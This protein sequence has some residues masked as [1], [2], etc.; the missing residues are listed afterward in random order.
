MRNPLGMV[1]VSLFL[2]DWGMKETV[3][4]WEIRAKAGG[5]FWSWTLSLFLEGVY[6]FQDISQGASLNWLDETTQ[7]SA[8]RSHPVSI[9]RMEESF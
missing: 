3:L 4:G 9:S 8:G 1:E 2:L 7:V 5:D 6:D